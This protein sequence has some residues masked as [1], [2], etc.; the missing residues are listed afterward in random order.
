MTVMAMKLKARMEALEKMT[1]KKMTY[2]KSQLMMRIQRKRRRRRSH[3]FIQYL[4]VDQSH[5]IETL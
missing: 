1:Y 3:L 5:Q 4:L 2:K